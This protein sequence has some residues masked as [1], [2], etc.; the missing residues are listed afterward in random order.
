MNINLEQDK[1]K[2]ITL[3]LIGVLS[4]IVIVLWCVNCKIAAVLALIIDGIAI[5][6]YFIKKN[7]NKDEESIYNSKLKNILKTYDAILVNSED[8]P[9]IK[10]RNVIKVTSMSDLI[11]AQIEIR[12]PVY[13]KKYENCCSFILLDSKE[14]CVYILK[15]NDSIVCPVEA[16]IEENI[17]APKANNGELIKTLKDLEKTTIIKISDSKLYKVS[18]I[19][20]KDNNKNKENPLPKVKQN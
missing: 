2:I 11:D 9:S 1:D 16:L 3:T 12:K 7:E 18:P 10:G 17:D 13:Y 6:N 19:R 15:L 14:V 4:I 5:S 20:K 8:V